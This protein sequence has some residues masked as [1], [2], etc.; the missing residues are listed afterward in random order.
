VGN[1]RY[2]FYWKNEE[3]SSRF[4][5]VGQ[6]PELEQRVSDS[7]EAALNTEDLKMYKT[8]LRLRNSAVPLQVEQAQLGTCIDIGR[9]IVEI[10]KTL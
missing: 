7:L 9:L 4:F 6:H 10:G 8:V 1:V 5:K 2:Y 3:K